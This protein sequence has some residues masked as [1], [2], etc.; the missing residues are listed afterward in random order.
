MYELFIVMIIHLCDVCLVHSM[1]DDDE[2]IEHGFVFGNKDTTDGDTTDNTKESKDEKPS[3]RQTR[4]VKDVKF[5]NSS[6]G[7]VPTEYS[8]KN[9]YDELIDHKSIEYPIGKLNGN[10]YLLSPKTGEIISVPFTNITEAQSSEGTY[11]ISHQIL[12]NHNTDGMVSNK[13][14][15]RKNGYF[16]PANK[17]HERSDAEDLYDEDAAL[18]Y[19]EN[20]KSVLPRTVS[21]SLEDI[22]H[23]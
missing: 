11:E 1:T 23:S 19:L 13:L 3:K 4:V 22:V 14:L 8:I 5:E 15:R 21:R 9:Q 7:W 18:D 20:Y 2:D 16:V 6:D 12:N 10:K 17:L